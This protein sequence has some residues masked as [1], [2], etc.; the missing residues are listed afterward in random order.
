MGD[1]IGSGSVHFY[2]CSTN[3]VQLSNWKYVIYG[4]LTTTDDSLSLDPNQCHYPLITY[5][6]QILT[7]YHT[8]LYRNVIMP[9]I[10]FNEKDDHI[11]RIVSKCSTLHEIYKPPWWCI[12]PWMN[13]IVMLIKEK[14]ASNMEL[15]RSDFSTNST[16]SSKD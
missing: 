10:S 14:F 9:A 5:L 16:D 13:V 11:K 8:F 7:F 2:F 15:H 4:C 1:D 3:V 6:I 12:G